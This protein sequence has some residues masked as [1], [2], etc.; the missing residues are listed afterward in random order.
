MCA[1]GSCEIFLA[2]TGAH[3]P[4]GA[5]IMLLRLLLNNGRL[6]KRHPS[7]RGEYLIAVWRAPTRPM[8]AA[9]ALSYI[10]L[11]VPMPPE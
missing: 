9:N 6:R 8:L 5:I 7:V 1:S 10:V 11:L 3:L 4:F 2:E